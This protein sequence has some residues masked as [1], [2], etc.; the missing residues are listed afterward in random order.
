MGECQVPYVY[1]EDAIE[2]LKTSL[3]ERRFSTYFTKAK[4]SGEI[5]M[6]LYLY[7]VRLAKSFLFPLGITEVVF[8]NAVNQVLIGE[9]GAEWHLDS[10]FRSKVL[11]TRSRASLKKATERVKFQG[12]GGGNV[13]PELTFDFWSNLFR[14]EYA[15]FWRT[16][17]SIAFPGLAR[18]GGRRE[19]QKLAKEINHFRNRVAHHESILDVNAPDILSKMIRLTNLR[20]PK[21]SEW[22]RHHT[23]VNIVMRSKPNLQ[24][25]IR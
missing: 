13:V 14:N 24:N 18:H 3:S 22:M 11:T 19:I 20:C 23:T 7:N 6:A 16:K 12:R 1:D 8:R 15:P 5:A 17:A 4:G 2:A 21:T 9:F 25:S 10:S